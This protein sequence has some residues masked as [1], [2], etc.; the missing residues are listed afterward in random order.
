[1]VTMQPREF[2]GNSRSKFCARNKTAYKLLISQDIGYYRSLQDFTIVK[3]STQFSVIN[4]NARHHRSER[5]GS[6]EDLTREQERTLL[7]QRSRNEFVTPASKKKQSDLF[8]G[9]VSKG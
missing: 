9:G 6:I 5:L 2:A 8:E 4:C 1:M 7:Q 3:F